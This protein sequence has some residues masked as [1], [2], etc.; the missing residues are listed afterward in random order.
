MLDLVHR[1]F[2]IE[3]GRTGVECGDTGRIHPDIVEESGKR[4]PAGMREV[5]SRCKRSDERF[6]TRGK[7]T[8]LDF[9]ELPQHLLL[10]RGLDLRGTRGEPFADILW[11]PVG[12]VPAQH[13]PDT[14]PQE[15]VPLVLV[16]RYK[17][18]LY[19]PVDE[20]EPVI[21]QR[22]DKLHVVG[23][24]HPVPFYPDAQFV[25]DSRPEPGIFAIRLHVSAVPLLF[26]HKEIVRPFGFVPGEPVD[27]LPV[28]DAGSND[29]CEGIGR[30]LVFGAVANSW[31]VVFPRG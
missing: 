2:H 10:V 16:N 31:N 3:I 6:H 5:D 27:E 15:F 4:E 25:R 30:D 11:H 23:N 28:V 8:L 24:R 14:L 1:L 26:A 12:K 20:P 22:G 9:P 13:D 18:L 7:R 17:T 29:P 21:V 19:A